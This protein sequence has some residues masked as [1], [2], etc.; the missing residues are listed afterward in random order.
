MLGRPH[1]G[2]PSQAGWQEG[3]S[4]RRRRWREPGERER[5]HVGAREVEHAHRVVVGVGDEDALARNG[6]ATR[7]AET[8][9]QGLAVEQPRLAVA[10]DRPTF[11]GGGV[12]PL[13]LVVVRVGDQQRALVPE[14]SE[15]VLK[16]YR[17]RPGSIAIT[18]LEEAFTDD[19][20]D[21]ALGR[22]LDHPDRARLAV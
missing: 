11:G 9:G 5:A 20:A 2:S 15:W 10:G 18:E 17:R 21:H 4:G 22:R 14:D 12:E 6:E 3:P 13:D 16:P 19:R 7:L 8:R 1:P